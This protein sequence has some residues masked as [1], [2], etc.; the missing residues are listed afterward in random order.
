MFAGCEERGV[1]VWHRSLVLRLRFRDAEALRYGRTLELSR[2]SVCTRRITTRPE[3][4]V[5]ASGDRR[6]KPLGTVTNPPVARLVIQE[7]AYSGE[8]WRAT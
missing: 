5:P 7:A 4:I 2:F 1:V 3:S 8:F 6:G